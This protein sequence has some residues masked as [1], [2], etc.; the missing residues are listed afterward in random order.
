MRLIFSASAYF[1]CLQ[2]VA[3]GEEVV[4]VSVVGVS[5]GVSM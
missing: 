1:F 3:G 5:V 2:V 4:C